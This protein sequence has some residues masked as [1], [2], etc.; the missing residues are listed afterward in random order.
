MTTK[1]TKQKKFYAETV[2]D[3]QEFFTDIQDNFFGERYS[4][5]IF[6][7][8]DKAEYGLVPSIGRERHTERSFEKYEQSIFSLFVRESAHLTDINPKNDFE[9]L[10]LAQ[11]HGLPTRLLDWSFNPF[12]ALFFAVTKSFDNDGAL[13]AL[14]APKR[15]SDNQINSGSPFQL[16]GDRKFLPRS[17]SGRVLN[18]EGL[19][20][21]HADPKKP[22]DTI[23]RTDWS[24]QKF[25]IKKDLKEEIQYY[26]FRLGIHYAKLFPELDGLAQ[27]LKWRHTIPGGIQISETR[28]SLNQDPTE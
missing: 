15:L 22:L 2:E 20:T 10:A 27:H 19:F 16:N 8:H 6:R 24:L 9:R 26:L 25:I 11:H 1:K 14:K 21:I 3:F 17:I 4:E 7:G 23:L 18:Q 12:I 5:W 13:W 28:K